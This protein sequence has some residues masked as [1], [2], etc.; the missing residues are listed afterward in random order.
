MTDT[1]HST[2][3][4]RTIALVDLGYLFTRNYR[5]AGK[6]APANAGADR[7]IADLDVIRLDVDHVIVCV[8]AAPY[9]RKQRFE[10]YKAHRPE[11]EPE[12]IAQRRDVVARLKRLGYAIA[13]AEGYEA[14]DCIATLARAYGQWCPEVLMVA[15]DKDIAQ[16]ITK[17]CIQHV[18]PH[19]SRDAERRDNG[20]CKRKFGV[21]PAQ[22]ILWQALCGDSDD[23][24]PGVKGIG[25]QK[26]REII[27]MLADKQLPATIEGLAALMANHKHKH[28]T[29][30]AAD[31]EAF[32]L[33]F[34][35]V[36]L[37]TNAPLDVEGLLIPPAPAP[38]DN[39]GIV[40]LPDYLRNE[41]PT[42]ML[43]DAEFPE[44]GEGED[45]F[46][47]VA[48]EPEPLPPPKP[49]IIGKDP[50]ADQFLTDFAREQAERADTERAILEKQAE[51]RRRIEQMAKDGH[52]RQAEKA[53][54]PISAVKDKPVNDTVTDAQFDPISRAPG[55]TGEQPALPPLPK[56][57]SKPA[58][59]PNRPGLAKATERSVTE[60]S[61]VQYG[62]TDGN[63]Q[64]GDLRGA[65]TVS[66]WIARS[67]LYKAFDTPEKVFAVLLRGRE[68]GLSATTALSGFHVIEGKPSASADLIRSLAERD[69]NCE[70]FMLVGA[71]SKQAT[72]ET[73]HRKQPRPV[74]Y[75]YTIEEAELAD[76][77]RPG[78]KG[79]PSN[80]V[81]RPK[82]M[83]TKTAASK[84]AR[85]V[86]PG[87][88]LGLYCAEELTG[89]SI[90]TLGVAA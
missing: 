86:Y 23:N 75:S 82:D 32:R 24:V 80:W 40:D 31:W 39:H 68:M 15:S 5:S 14:D 50:N 46:A 73:K 6:N 8:D 36:T 53:A 17:T 70:Y 21:Y 34:E 88:C 78:W 30:V 26:A 3:D 35:L 65:W 66:N 84:L 55:A 10:A 74:Q 57:E 13:R 54:A 69:P 29:A 12:E 77:T 64:P 11:R 27:A 47:P 52:D 44:V 63:L 59:S 60:M 33:S 49:P 89:E 56:A 19:G 51:T 45:P 87:A 81:K 62:L 2:R 41:T 58:E 42:G 25:E 43:I 67:G 4:Y 83:L 20:A 28:L 38:A 76:L 18:P 9:L 85:L 61:I 7:T 48:P 16:C 79:Q 37:D 71:D 90:D 1:T 72:W 22:M